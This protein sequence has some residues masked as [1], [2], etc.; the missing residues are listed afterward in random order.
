LPGRKSDEKAE[1]LTPP[2][3][4]P[5]EKLVPKP[6]SLLP[7]FEPDGVGEVAADPGT[8]PYRWLDQ[9]DQFL[10]ESD[11]YPPGRDPFRER[12]GIALGWFTGIELNVVRPHILALVNNSVLGPGDIVSG[13]F[14]N[15]TQLPFGVSEHDAGGDLDWTVIPKIHVG[16]RFENGLGE[17]MASYR[18]IHADA[19]GAILNFD[20]AGAGQFNTVSTNHV[21][22]VVYGFT[23]RT[24][25]L[26]W[27][28]PAVRRYSLG[29]RVASWVFDTT[30]TGHQTLLERAGNVFVGGGPVL[31]YDWTWLTPSRSMTFNGGF[32]VAGVGGFNYQRF[33]EK[34]IV[35]GSVVNARGRTDGQ[36]TATPILSVWGGLSWIPEWGSQNWRF[37][38]GY[39]WERWWDLTDLGGNQKPSSSQNE[40]TLQGPFVRG[41]FR[42]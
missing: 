3:E 41:E 18:F 24:D 17:W 32:D 26:A 14:T 10:D 16:Y 21:L 7:R 5:L 6:E 4:T 29:L 33:T 36:G 30:A 40:L 35:S 12:P 15:S 19:S 1:E 37:S 39:R 11:P 13:T 34:A 42:W 2:G 31:A 28:F 8:T 23:D 38:A 20:A 9:N 27:Y 22:D 25:G